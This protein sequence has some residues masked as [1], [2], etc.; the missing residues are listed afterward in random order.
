MKKRIIFA[1]FASIVMGMAV[2]GVAYAKSYDKLPK[3]AWTQKPNAD[4]VPIQEE[5][6]IVPGTNTIYLHVGEEKASQTKVWAPDTL[7]AVD[8]ST[9]K[10]KWTYSF[11]NTGYRW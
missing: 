8:Q 7:R 1:F 4:Y 10:V 9:G 11:A 2:Y 6:Y 5:I 3:E